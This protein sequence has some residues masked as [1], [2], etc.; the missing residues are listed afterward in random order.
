MTKLALNDDMWHTYNKDQF[1]FLFV[2]ANVITR[3]VHT[4]AV[5][6]ESI[7]TNENFVVPQ[8]YRCSRLSKGQYCILKMKG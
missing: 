8:L 3:N 2:N 5:G 4:L 7:M 1:S 6:P